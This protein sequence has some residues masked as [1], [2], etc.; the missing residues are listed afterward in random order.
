MNI[1]QVNQ[2]MKKGKTISTSSEVYK[3]M[4]GISD[5]ARKIT[6]NMNNVYHNQS[7]LRRLFSE[8]TGKEVDDSFSLFPP[9][10]TDYGKN[11][12]IGKGVFINAACHFQDQGGITIGDN[13]FIGHNVVLAT[14]NHGIS[15][16]DRATLYPAPINI[17]INVWIGSNCT[18]LPGVTIGNNAIIGAGSVV[19]KN[20]ESNTIVAGVPAKRI[21]K[22]QN[23]L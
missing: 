7:T 14:L 3:I 4:I 8:L 10:Y 9:F 11:I 18:I 17:G 21:K 1:Q 16:A 23:H 19:T 13:T 2:Y 5:E 22:I 6:M 15:P 20:V 12:T